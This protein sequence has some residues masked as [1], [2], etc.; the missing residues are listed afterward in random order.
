MTK[1]QL[2]ELCCKAIDEN[3]ET[4]I[5]LGREVYKT[6]ELGFKEFQTMDTVCSFM[7]KVGLP[8]EKNIAYTGCKTTANPEKKGQPRV[9]IMSEL[10][11]V[12]CPEHPEAA[13]NGNAHA[14]GHNMQM[15]TMFG[16]AIGIMKSGVAEHLDGVMD[17]IAIPAEEC[18]DYE[19]RNQLVEEGKIKYTGGKQE[20]LYRGG[21]DDTNMII[22]CHAWPFAPQENKCCIVNTK[23]NGFINKTVTFL[24]RSA[25]AGNAPHDGINALNMAQL[26]LNNINAQRETF[27]DQ[28]KVRVS[29]IITQGGYIVNAIPAKVTMEVMVRAASLDAMMDASEKVNRSFH[30]AA[31]AMGGEVLIKDSIGY[32]PLDSDH[33]LD[34]VFADN[35]IAELGGKEDQLIYNMAVAGSTDLGDMSQIM[36]CTHIWMGGI[37]G[38]LHSKDFKIVDE[39]EAYIHP[40]KLLAKTLVDLLYDDAK[41]A[42]KIIN[43]YQPTFT[44]E[45]Y[46]QFMDQHNVTLDYNYMK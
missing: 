37:T 22:Q 42:Q 1:E 4:I 19:Y 45:S 33:Q 24:G 28:D 26:A 12:M 16:A 10:D 25:H 29:A 31:L 11:S 7:E 32:L 27:K 20:Y 3:R 39:E 9:A 15:A 35:L 41:V 6:P 17:F 40:A 5:A 14:C 23:A 30:A 46:L 21:L 18:L 44:K 13:A 2:K 38:G 43:D 36:P 34:Q 8:V